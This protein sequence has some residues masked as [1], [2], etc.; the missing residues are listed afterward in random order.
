MNN[1]NYDLIRHIVGKALYESDEI[2][3]TKLEYEDIETALWATAGEVSLG[4]YLLHPEERD[5]YENHPKVK[6]SDNE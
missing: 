2:D 5:V 4:S 3:C 1:Y 6:D